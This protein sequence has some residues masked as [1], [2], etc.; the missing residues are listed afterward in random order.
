VRWLGDMLVHFS[1]TEKCIY[2]VCRK[3]IVLPI[4]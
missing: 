1:G 3:I 4:V 2:H